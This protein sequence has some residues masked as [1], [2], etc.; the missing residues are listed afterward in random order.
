MQLRKDREEK[1][2]TE[3]KYYKHRDRGMQGIRGRQ[4]REMV[5]RQLK[6]NGCR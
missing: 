2:K 3:E 4:K 5:R 6:E 1:G